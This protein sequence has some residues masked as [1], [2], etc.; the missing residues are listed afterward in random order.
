MRHREGIRPI[1]DLGLGRARW[2]RS[3]RA[4]RCVCAIIS[5]ILREQ[6][7]THH[8]VADLDRAGEA[9]GVGAAMSS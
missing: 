3:R 7:L 4:L 6:F 2:P 9:L 8:V 1:R 5:R